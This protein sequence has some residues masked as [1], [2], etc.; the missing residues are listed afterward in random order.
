MN[1]RIFFKAG[2]DRQISKT[3]AARNAIGQQACEAILEHTKSWFAFAF[4]ENLPR[5]ARRNGSINNDVG[6]MTPLPAAR[7]AELCK[8]NTV[9]FR[10]PGKLHAGD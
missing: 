8:D 10:D 6:D 2:L 7:C 1:S 9:G 5:T 3:T 4:A